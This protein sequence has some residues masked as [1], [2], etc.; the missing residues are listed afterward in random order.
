MVFF[1]VRVLRIGGQIS[2]TYGRLVLTGLTSL[3][4]VQVFWNLA[5]SVGLVPV[6]GISFPFLSYGVTQ[7]LVQLCVMGMMLSVTRR[8]YM[9]A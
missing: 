8:R 2:H 4:A 3:F 1:F 6:M 9:P 7:L 5:M